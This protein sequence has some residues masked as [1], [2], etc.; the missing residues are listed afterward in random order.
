MEGVRAALASQRR[1]LWTTFTWVPVGYVIM[2]KLVHP[3][4]VTGR[5]MEP[6]LENRDRLFTTAFWK[7]KRGDVYVFKYS[8]TVWRAV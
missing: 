5:S 4:I 6:T 2:D 8:P 3:V 1:T 7:P